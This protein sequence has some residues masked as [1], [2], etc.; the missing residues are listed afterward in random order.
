MAKQIDYV[1]LAK[2]KLEEISN[3][4]KKRDTKK[5]RIRRRYALIYDLHNI[6]GYSAGRVVQYLA[7]NHKLSVTKRYLINVLREWDDDIF[8]KKC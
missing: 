7:K 5:N 6:E 1:F 2:K 4:P 8:R 3:M